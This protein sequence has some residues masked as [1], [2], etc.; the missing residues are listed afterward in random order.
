MGM[1]FLIL[2]ILMFGFLVFIHE[3]GHFLFAKRNGV[4]VEE[5]GF[6]FPPRAYG[7]K[8]GRTIYS[9]NWLPLGGFVRLKGEEGGEDV[10]MPAGEKS[11][12]GTAQPKPEKGTFV[13]ASTWAKTKILLAG[14]VMNL[15]TAIVLFWGL[16]LAGMPVLGELDP[17][18]LSPISIGEQRV[19]VADV[20][21]DSPAARAGLEKGDFLIE[22]EG[23]PLRSAEGL[24]EVTRANQG[25]EISLKVE[26]GGQ[27]R[28]LS[29]QLRQSS[30]GGALGVT[31]GE[32]AKQRYSFFEAPVAAVHYTY[33]LFSKTILAIFQLLA[34]IPDLIAGVFQSGVPKEANEAAGPLGIVMLM[35][36]LRSFD[37]S[38][39][40]LI[41][42]NISVALAAFNVLPL[43][44]LDGGRLAV[45]LARKIPGVRISED[46]EARYHTFGFLAL[47]F[48]LVLPITIFDIRRFF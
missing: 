39:F 40:L 35:L 42:A 13:A 38:Y 21:P 37:P 17:K 20:S 3:L 46:A 9:I 27:E 4:E 1:L 47:I 28:T 11:P 36:A 45:I 2:V 8:V 31:P 5:F 43:P 16:A 24:T 33:I 26:S 30:E 41:M 10:L 25:E 29:V 23:R 6:G 15:V 32:I 19:V 22:A 48:L 34:N 14:V 12:I 18:Y 44:A 7:K